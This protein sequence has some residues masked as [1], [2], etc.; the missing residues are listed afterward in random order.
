MPYF[1]YVVSDKEGKR[2]TAVEEA[3]D[4]DSL[5]TRLQAQ[6]QF[7]I[8]ISPTTGTRTTGFKVK[9]AFTRSRIKLEDLV[10]FARQLSTMLN[11]GVT[12]LKSLEV[13]SMQ[14]ES[15]KLSDTIVR[16]RLDL[17]KGSS[18]S[19][20]LAKYPKVFNNFWVSLSEV[21]EA[22]GTLPLVL[23]RL[24]SYLEQKADFERAILSAMLYP[25]IL[26]VIC[27]IALTVFSFVIIP[28][29][30]TIFTSFSIKIPT[31]TAFVLNSF[32]FVRERFW[33][34][35][36]GMIA[37]I[38]LL[39][40]YIQTPIGRRQFESFLFNIPILGKFCKNL[41]TE[42]FTSHLSILVD[43]GVPLLYALEITERIVDNVTVAGIINKVKSS[44]RE[45]KLVARPME[46][47]GFFP[48]MVVQ[49]ILIGEE[50]GELGN[51]LKRVAAFYQSI[52]ETFLK[53]FAIIFEPV[54]LV[55]MGVVIGT[56]VISM[57]LPIFSIVT[58]GGGRLR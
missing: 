44:V 54:M 56:I 53:R 57:F 15:K 7:V 11:A 8:N 9:Q 30:N 4:K 22:S 5:I 29:F 40:Q 28:R 25:A 1:R 3:A 49:M 35:L 38:I 52:I 43:S 46:E 17:E 34:I 39:R 10:I 47:S 24:A 58:M 2:K 6:G 27:I 48:P 55:F 20:S 16:V 51:M 26:V 31:L 13:I 19:Q 36:A 45:G 42:R 23:D 33:L 41:Y 14:V 21:G 18:L 37:V 32:G 50:T 12:L